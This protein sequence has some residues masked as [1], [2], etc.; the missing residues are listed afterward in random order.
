M[1][2]DTPFSMKEEVQDA[3][4][5]FSKIN[6]LKL[7][8]N[9]KTDQM[10][11]KKKAQKTA[12]ATYKFGMMNPAMGANPFT[13]GLEEKKGGDK[14]SVINKA[15]KSAGHLMEKK[16]IGKSRLTTIK[17]STLSG[18]TK[19]AIRRLAR[20]GGVKRISKPIYDEIRNELEL[21][22]KSTMR[23]AVTYCEHAKRRTIKPL[24]VVVALK[25]RGRDL[26]GYGQA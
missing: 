7:K 14:Y 17:E 15:K 2:V 9:D 12:F 8:M 13:S 10:Y 6:E 18:I 23:D 25:R 20:R 3:K 26:Y 11:D 1:N 19:P 5:S 21:F 16:N 22:L 4:Y 24:D